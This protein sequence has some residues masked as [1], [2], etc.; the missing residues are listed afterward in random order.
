MPKV[1]VPIT[2]MFTLNMSNQANEY[3]AKN[4]FGGGGGQYVEGMA[5]VPGG[6]ASDNV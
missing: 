4:E 5:M 2:T 3:L 6:A 1:M